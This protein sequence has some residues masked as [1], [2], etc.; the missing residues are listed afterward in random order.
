MQRQTAKLVCFC[1]LLLV[2]TS[3]ILQAQ[4]QSGS[5]VGTVTDSEGQPIPNVHISIYGPALIASGIS[6]ITNQD[7]YYRFPTLPP[8]EYKVDF[9]LEGFEHLVREQIK[10]Q[11]GKTFSLNTEL[12]IAPVQEITIVHGSPLIDVRGNN[13]GT[14][15]SDKDLENLPTSRDVWS[16]L[17]QMPS[18]VN[19]N[20]NVG[21]NESGLQTT[22]N[23]RGGSWSQNTHSLD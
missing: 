7:G 19:R 12:S 3:K 5:I 10:V 22:F 6:T 21:G 23:A 17:E 13:I 9:F 4:P 8:G 14:H 2:C 18:M 15:Y 20:F 16:V 11:V 1:L